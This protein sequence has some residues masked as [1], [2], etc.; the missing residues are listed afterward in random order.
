MQA[1]INKPI[2]GM[3]LSPGEQQEKLLNSCLEDE[4]LFGM[5]VTLTGDKES[6]WVPVCTAYG[7]EGWVLASDLLLDNEAAQRWEN[8]AQDIVLH[9]NFADIFV[10][11][12]VEAKPVVCGLPRGARV[13]RNG[14]ERDGWQ[15]VKLPDGSCGW[16]CSSFLG[17]YWTKPCC[18]EQGK[19]RR[20][21]TDAARLYGGTQYRWGGKTPQGIDCSGLCS[22]AYLLCGIKIWRNSCLKKGYPIHEI[23]ISEMR[24]GDLIYFPGHIAMYL[25]NGEYIHSTGR[26]GDNGVTVNS[27]YPESA[28]YR[29]DLP[30]KIRQ[31]GS[32]F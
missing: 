24:E 20:A 15:P 31:V 27:L 2:C 29:A 4:L 1:I 6:G 11:P 3:Y 8:E 7:Y 19:L 23:P 18:T 25:G 22:M 13:A 17:R 32:L 30:P 26:A 28:R 9:K 14:E 12:R 16:I 10:E 5:I 21:L